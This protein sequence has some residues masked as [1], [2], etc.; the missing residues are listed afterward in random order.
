M[1]TLRRHAASVSIAHGE[2]G[3]ARLT[4]LAV[5]CSCLLALLLAANAGAALTHPF[6]REITGTSL[7]KFEKGLCG[8]GI[9]PI[10][11]EIYVLNF[12]EDAVDVF[13]SFGNFKRR[14]SGAD[15]PGT[16][17]SA[18]GSGPAC[19]FI[20]SVGVN[21]DTGQVAVGN[22]A[23]QRVHLFDGLGNFEGFLNP[24]LTPEKEWGINFLNTMTDQLTGDIYVSS[25]HY[26]PPID[27]GRIHRFSASGEYKSEI[28][29][30]FYPWTMSTDDEGNLYVTTYGN[31][32]VL[33]YNNAGEKIDEFKSTPYGPLNETRFAAAG[34]DHVFIMDNY[35]R[36]FGGGSSGTVGAIRE[37][38][39][40]G[41]YIGDTLGLD[42]PAGYIDY[43]I[44]G[45]T[46]S[47]GGRVY[48]AYDGADGGKVLVFG[49]P[50]I[51]PSVTTNPPTE[52]G[53]AS[54]TLSGTVNPSSDSLGATCKI[55][56]GLDAAYGSSQPCSIANIPPGKSDVAVSIHL[57]GLSTN[58]EYHY[59]VV[60]SNANGATEGPDKTVTPPAVLDTTTKAAT[61][62]TRTSATL[63]GSLNPDGSEAKYV[64]EYGLE[65]SY[66]ETVP[67]LPGN[68][69]GSGSASVDVSQAISGLQPGSLYHYRIRASNSLGSTPGLDGTFETLP[70]VKDLSTE[71]A[72]DILRNTATLHGS[73]D[74]NG[75]ETHYFFQYGPTTDYG[76]I[77]P[78]PPGANADPAPG[79]ITVSQPIAGLLPETTYHYRV[80]ATNALGATI[81]ADR[82]FTT[83][84]AV[85][86]VT[87]GAATEITPTTATLSGAFDPNGEATHYYFQYGI[88]GNFA[89]RVPAAPGAVGPSGNGSTP[90]SIEV[91]GLK[92]GTKY[93]YRLAV[94][95]VAGTTYGAPQSFTTAQVPTIE[96]LTATNLGQ[97]SAD[98]NARINPNGEATT[99]RFEYGLTNEYGTNAPIP[100]GAL[101]ASSTG[102]SVSV[103]L[104]GLQ[105]GSTYHFR[106]VA[107]NKW[108]VQATLGQTF[109]FSPPNCPN[110]LIR[111]QTG[112]NYLP[113]CRAYELVTP[114]VAKGVT[115]GVAGPTSTMA[116][117]PSRFAFNGSLGLIEEAGDPPN[118]FFD[119]YVATRT[120]SGWKTRFVGIPAKE[121]L[122]TG[123]RSGEGGVSTIPTNTGMD[124]YVIWDGGA[125]NFCIPPG[126]NEYR[127]HNAPFLYD[128]SGQRLTRLPTNLKEVTD[129]EIFD[130]PTGNFEL[131]LGRGSQETSGD[132]NH[133][134]FAWDYPAFAPGGR[135][136]TPGTVYDN[137]ITQNTVTA[138]S[139]TQNGD[140]IPRETPVDGGP[141][142][143]LEVRR[144]SED[145]SHILMAAAAGQRECDFFNNCTY[146]YPIHL[147]M[148]VNQAI[149]YDVTDGALGRLLGMTRDGSMVSFESKEQ[150]T[151]DDHDNSVDIYQWSEQGGVTRVTTGD[152]VS[153]DQDGCSAVWAEGCDAVFVKT[154]GSA[155][156]EVLGGCPCYSHRG[157]H[158]NAMARRSGELYFYSPEQLDGSQGIAG[159]RNL[160][161]HRDGETQYVT[162]LKFDEPLSRIQVSPDN[163]HA[164]FITPS[165]LTAYDN[166]RRVM[167]YVYEPATGAIRCASCLPDGGKPEFDVAASQNG[168]FMTDDGRAFFSTSD[169][170]VP[171]DTNDLR[172]VYEF[173]EGRA[174]LITTGT[175]SKD[176]GL[177]GAAGVVGVSSD[178][179]DLYFSTYDSI[180]PADQN[181]PQMKVYDAR[182]NGGIPFAPPDAP[183]V[184]ADECHG[185][186]NPQ[187][188]LRPVLTESSLAS[189]NHAKKK[190]KKKKAKKKAQK[191][192]KK[193]KA[194][195]KRHQQRDRAGR[196]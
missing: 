5:L 186:G 28:K 101:A 116:T 53:H 140:D 191:K 30:I 137:D 147:W 76:T 120:E 170:V 77:E 84:P 80:I 18:Y 109:T 179:T 91:T 158:D 127:G 66:G 108:G 81:G 15:S 65:P 46:A 8:I 103:H 78:A 150:V 90:V 183:C 134:V 64:F 70:A 25:Y 157:N 33:K 125:S 21:S 56:Y 95:N 22:L 1:G 37:F 51:V 136:A 138:V 68:S 49:P 10:H 177:S 40:N 114:G 161:T 16:F 98:L 85:L 188:G 133:F 3:R 166:D 175:A 106:V 146:E 14:I 93:D 12:G 156:E 185:P 141:E 118:V 44:Q 115:L 24:A 196:R 184:A 82:T 23:Q 189:G 26:D 88:E 102:Q 7:G 87:T 180:I 178:G 75:E 172:D 45:L 72:T 89:N 187:P 173:V 27:E 62:V 155:N 13:D 2:V 9:D 60:A 167:M 176:R 86:G 162:T 132:L 104:E 153:G 144:V 92:A 143:L 107:E 79:E 55:E 193:A 74:P 42:L 154:Q 99:Y 96:A 121:S 119:L 174:Q 171:K 67:A 105:S 63:N 4:A 47:N 139:K 41:E 192:K 32:G 36:Q 131:P 29:G 169:P 17:E 59:R 159:Q 163:S 100:D 164:A 160:Y 151:A 168:L 129:W 61:A 19:G 190:A 142:E 182:V 94:E 113:D 43:S 54:A 194:R 48:L 112:A 97:T 126:C 6:E 38:D 195:K 122:V 73:L 135:T 148:R 181:G 152:G 165:R 57:T 128:A 50:V 31:E 83:E 52:I 124:R 149:T 117:A 145:G 11:E 58:T 39:E 20:H 69:A 35:Y 110:E 111:Q 123:P 71:P 34:G 130:K